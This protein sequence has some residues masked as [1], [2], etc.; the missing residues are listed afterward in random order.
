MNRQPCILLAEDNEDD[1]FF[2]KRAAKA[3]S[4][5]H[6]IHVAADGRAAIDYLAGLNGYGDREKH[7]LPFLVFLDLK[8]PHKSGLD[9]LEWIR[10]QPHLQTMLVLILTTSREQS[11]VQRAYRLGVNAFLVKPPNAGNLTELM[12]LVRSFWIENP[13]LAISPPGASVMEMLAQG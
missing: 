3:A 4:I 9:V 11:D 12:K 13:Q 8:M 6:P 5:L 1:V 10:S 7:P 2:M